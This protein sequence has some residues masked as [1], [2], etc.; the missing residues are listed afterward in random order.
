MV[1][2]IITIFHGK[3]FVAIGTS[4][5]LK[6]KKAENMSKA[7]MIEKNSLVLWYV[8]DLVNDHLDYSLEVPFSK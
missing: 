1:K 2:V 4:K 8:F 7:V 3:I 5:F 6:K